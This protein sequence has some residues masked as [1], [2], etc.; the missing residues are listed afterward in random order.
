MVLIGGE[1][2]RCQEGVV[3]IA[4]RHLPADDLQLPGRNLL[5]SDS[6]SDC[7]LTGIP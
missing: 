2:A 6:A 7:S 4:G 5:I 3:G 1:A